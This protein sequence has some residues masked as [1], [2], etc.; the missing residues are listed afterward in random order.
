MVR[1]LPCASNVTISASFATAAGAALSALATASASER[2]VVSTE[3]AYAAKGA[4]QA[5]NANVN[6]AR[7]TSS[8]GAT[9]R[10]ARQPSA[11]P[12]L[13]SL[14]HECAPPIYAN[15]KSQA[16]LRHSFIEKAMDRT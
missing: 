4:A 12:G 3:A 5:S 9:R 11:A 1:M 7:M 8:F 16:Y 14:K 15:R 2:A 10:G 6:E 13:G